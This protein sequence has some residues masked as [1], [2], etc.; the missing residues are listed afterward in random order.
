MAQY[1]RASCSGEIDTACPKLTESFVYFADGL[2]EERFQD[3]SAP[4][5]KIRP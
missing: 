5:R 1:A 3:R 4:T 2:Q